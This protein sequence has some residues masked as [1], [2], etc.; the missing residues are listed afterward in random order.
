MLKLALCGAIAATALLAAPVGYSSAEAKVYNLRYADIGP[1]RGPRAGALK[2][3][4]AELESRS[5]GDI[6]IKFFWSQSLVKGKATMKAVGSGLSDTGTVIGV[7]TPAEFPVWNYANTPFLH[8]DAWIGMRTW[9]EMR[10]N[11]PELLKETTR[12][13]ITIIANNTTGPVQLLTAKKAVTSIGD[14]QGM[15]IRTTGGWTHLFK[16]LG[17]VPVKI[18]FGE[19]YSALDRGTIDGTVNY[20][21]FVK[22]YKHYEVASHVTEASMGQLLGYG[23][24]INTKLLNGM[25]KKLQDIILSTSDE[26]MDVYAK[27]YMDASDEAKTAMTKGIDG[28]KVAFHQLSSGERAKWVAAAASFKV[29]WIAKMKKRGMDT[30][31]FLAKF[32]KIHAKYKKIVAEK[33]YPWASTN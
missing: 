32:D 14:L 25:P 11:S 23:I 27:M 8:S 15:K 12:Q 19:L 26:Y 6:K 16:A 2:W 33:G 10:Q 1:P 17:A 29:E 9:F 31:A 21:P 4:A 5:G 22:A 18:G 13:K 3:W 24:A 28:R 30:D 7:Y 20:T